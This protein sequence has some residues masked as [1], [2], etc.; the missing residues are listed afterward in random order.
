MNKWST[1]IKTIL[2]IGISLVWLINGLFCKVLDFVPRHELIVSRIL[3]TDYASIFTKL[4]GI[5]EILMV[6]WIL[7]GIKSRHCAI[8]QI[9]VVASMN[10]LE[11]I[12][13]PDL[14][15]FGRF[16][17]VFAVIFML[18]IYINEFRIKDRLYILNTNKEG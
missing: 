7:S 13:V 15:L 1:F 5:A 12:L 18:I 14:L 6:V 8:F 17:I 3:G 11:F 16:N 2:T 9:V 4:I 10:V